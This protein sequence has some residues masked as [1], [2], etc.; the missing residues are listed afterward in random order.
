VQPRITDFEFAGNPIKAKLTIDND[1]GRKLY[2]MKGYTTNSSDRGYDAVSDAEVPHFEKYGDALA[3]SIYAQDICRPKVV[4][5]NLVQIKN[6]YSYTA[7]DKLEIEFKSE[8]S[9]I[10]PGLLVPEI[11]AKFSE[12]QMETYTL[13]N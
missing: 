12:S 9:K 8:D 3:A 10:Y 5:L 13:V 11:G 4:F 6:D 1:V 2:G 7:G